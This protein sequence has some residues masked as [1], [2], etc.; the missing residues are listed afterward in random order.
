MFI[1]YLFQ[2][3]AYKF[4][5]GNHFLILEEQDEMPKIQNQDPNTLLKGNKLKCAL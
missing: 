1:I 3:L 4:A 5:S 2:I